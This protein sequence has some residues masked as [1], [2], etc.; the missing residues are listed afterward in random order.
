MP[1]TL[2]IKPGGELEKKILQQISDRVKAAETSHCKRAEQWAK[3]ENMMIGAF[4]E[5]E[6]DAVR[7]NKRDNSGIPD[8]TTIQIPYTYGAIMAVH[9]YL[10][11]VFLAR[12]PVHQVMGRHGESS[13]QTQA[14]EALLDYNVGVG[15]HLPP[16][17]IYMQDLPKYGEAILSVAWEEETKRVAEIVDVPEELEP[18]VPTGKMLRKKRTREYPGYKGNRVRNVSPTRFMTDPRYPRHDFQNGEFVILLV[19]QSYLTLKEGE[20]KDRYVNI[21]MIRKNN[22]GSW[23]SGGQLHMAT[24][25]SRLERGQPEDFTITGTEKSKIGSDV[26][27]LFEVYV[28]LIPKDWGLGAGTLP[29]KWVFTATWDLHT[30]I[31]ARPLGYLHDMFPFAL[32]EID[33]EAYGQ[34]SRSFVELLDPVQRTIDWLINSHM[35]NARQI[36]NNMFVVDPSR[37]EMRDFNSPNPGLFVRLKPSAYG[38]DPGSAMRQLQVTDTTRQN[39][40]DIDFMYDV[41]QRLGFNDQVLGMPAPSSRRS[42]AEVRTTSQF[43]VGRMKTIADFASATGWRDMSVMIISNCQQFYEGDMKLRIVGDLAESAGPGFMNV[44]PESIT[45]FFD[46]VPVDGTLP[47]DRFAQ[48]NL[49]REMMQ[50]VSTIPDVAAQFDMG[51]IFQWV[52]QLAGLRNI[53]QFKIQL[54]PDAQ[55]ERAAQAGN[56]Q[57]LRNGDPNKLPA[58]DQLSG[59]GPIG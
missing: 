55:L 10:C 49:W 46:P 54:T 15:R 57:T 16:L 59:M 5:K 13:Q 56:A 35:Y 58:Q 41:G 14:L 9:S 51:K 42:A 47:A 20:A 22:K 34:F 23:L 27:R 48:A 30:V 40:Q 37:V 44:T 1:Y 19:E 12:T 18:G 21:E 50:Q 39:L 31:E 28:N 53:N 45:G 6:L 11:S 2:K 7:R 17:F 24:E 43:A 4:P 3:A 52:A 25:T 38:S 8:Y 33:P 26:F 29:E 36:M 32:I